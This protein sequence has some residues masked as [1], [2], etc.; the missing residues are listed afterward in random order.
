MMLLAALIML[1]LVDDA[2]EGQP[3]RHSSWWLA[4]LALVGMLSHMT[5]A[6]PVGI[7]ALWFYL[8]RRSPSPMSRNWSARAPI[9]CLPPIQPR[10]RFRGRTAWR[11][12]DLVRA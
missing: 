12:E 8:E 4:A 1:L 9:R 10:W 5:M 6:A 2:V 7:S 11:G 3:V